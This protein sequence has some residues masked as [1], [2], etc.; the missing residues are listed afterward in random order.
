MRSWITPLGCFLPLV[1][2]AAC[3]SKP[4]L[5]TD[6]SADADTDTDVDSDSDADADAD[7]D[8][9]ADADVDTDP[10]DTAP[11]D[12]GTVA[13]PVPIDTGNPGFGLVLNEILADPDGVIGDANCDG[14]VNSVDDEFVEIVN[15]GTIDVDLSFATISD[16]IGPKHVFLPGS[17]LTPGG[18]AVVFAAGVPTFDGSNP[19]SWCDPL[20]ADV[21]VQVA[22]TGGL[23]LNNDG[24]TV[25]LTGPLGTVLLAVTYGAEGGTNQSLNLKP[26]LDPASS[27]VLHT[28]MPDATTSWSPGRRA[29]LDAFASPAPDTAT[30]DTAPIVDTAVNNAW[31]GLIINEILV[32]PDAVLGDANCDGLVDPSDDEFVEIVNISGS[33]IDLNGLSVRDDFAVRHAFVSSTVIPALGAAVLFGSGSPA[34]PWPVGVTSFVADTGSLG[35]DNG[36]DT[37]SLVDTSTGAVVL[38]QSW[39]AGQADNNQSINRNPDLSQHAFVDHGSVAGAIG[40]QSPGFRVDGTTFES[41]SVP[42]DTGSGGG[43]GLLVINE[44][45]ADPSSVDGDW[46]CDGTIDASQDEFLELVNTSGADL[47]LTGWTIYDG[48]PILRDSITAGTILAPGES[49]VVFGGGAPVFAGAAYP[50]CAALP[51]SVHISIASTGLLGLSNVGDIVSVYDAG[52]SLVDSYQFGAEGAN[53]TSLV[54]EPELTGAVFVEHLTAVGAN[55]EASPGTRR[56]GTAL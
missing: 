28:T 42:I 38:S 22:S 26:E 1:L 16:A 10:P 13:P 45:G 23:G 39:V 20:P 52:G 51:A 36:G 27:Y 31:T 18:V 34:C 46:N 8:S 49:L 32:D 4:P 24:D 54:R 5:E 37:L 6:G 17:V 43:S 3:Q 30:N 44:I 47:D 41:G 40:V 53:D 35:L 50:W 9:D 14:S 19:A 21:I 2:L 12:T 33:D 15:I 55:R 11:P 25:T 29:N 48:V 7:A 56:D